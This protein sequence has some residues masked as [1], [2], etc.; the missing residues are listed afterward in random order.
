MA[1]KRA[2]PSESGLRPRSPLRTTLYFVY[3][4]VD[5]SGFMTAGTTGELLFSWLHISDLHLVTEM[6]PTGLVSDA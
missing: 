4:I 2:Q 6:M 5:R 3:K 1:I